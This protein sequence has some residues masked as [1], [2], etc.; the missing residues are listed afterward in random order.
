MRYKDSI[1][2]AI[3]I[4]RTVNNMAYREIAEKLGVSIYKVKKVIHERQGSGQRKGK[5]KKKERRKN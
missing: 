4:E 2:E 3:W 5:G 1:D